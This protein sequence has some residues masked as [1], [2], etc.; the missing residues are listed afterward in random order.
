[1]I[2]INIGLILIAEINAAHKRDIQIKELMNTNS[3]VEVCRY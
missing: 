1:M 2:N 3:Y